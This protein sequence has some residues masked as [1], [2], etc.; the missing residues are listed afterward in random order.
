MRCDQAVHDVP[1]VPM[2][3]CRLVSFSSELAEQA[4][5]TIADHS[6]RLAGSALR[7]SLLRSYRDPFLVVLECATVREQR[8]QAS[9]KVTRRG[10]R[11]LSAPTPVRYSTL[12]VHLIIT[13]N[14]QT[15]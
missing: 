4:A 13:H 11:F 3:S 12:C 10:F 15:R 9:G 6:E 8:D 1:T 7:E 5:A 14:H 2:D